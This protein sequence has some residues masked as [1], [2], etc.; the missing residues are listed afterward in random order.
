MTLQASEIV[1]FIYC[2]RAWWYARQ[3]EASANV[4]ELRAGTRWHR[5]HGRKV[6]GAGCLRVLGY[7]FL[8]AA[9]GFAVIYLTSNVLK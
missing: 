2:R 7:I 5:D 4:K 6:L 9:V 1:Q 8:L 3:G